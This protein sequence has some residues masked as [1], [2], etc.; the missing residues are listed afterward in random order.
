MGVTV[1]NWIEWYVDG[2]DID[3]LNLCWFGLFI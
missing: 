2:R 3:Y 1:N